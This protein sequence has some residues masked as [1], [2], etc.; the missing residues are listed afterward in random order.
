MADRHFLVV[1]HTGR[2]ETLDA[3]IA[4]CRKLIADGVIPVL[5]PSDRDDVLAKAPDLRVQTLGDRVSID[6]LE[7]AIIL[8]G[9][10]L[11]VQLLN[12]MNSANYKSVAKVPKPSPFV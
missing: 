6:E 8:G 5:S 11:T 3:A 9:N 7:L 1:S 12:T 2:A 10:T 4:V